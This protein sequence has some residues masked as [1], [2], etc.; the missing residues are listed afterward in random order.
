MPENAAMTAGTSMTYQGGRPLHRYL[1]WYTLAFAANTSLTALTE[2]LLS[3]REV[4]RRGGPC[5]MRW[6]IGR[7]R[8]PG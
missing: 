1:L 2:D 3:H 7:R 4:V 6:R 5:C 8:I